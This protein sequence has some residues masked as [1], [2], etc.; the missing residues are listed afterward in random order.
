MTTLVV[1]LKLFRLKAE[2]IK[3]TRLP[4]RKYLPAIASSGEAG[5]SNY[6]TKHGFKMLFFLTV[7]SLYT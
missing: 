3:R 5:G 4:Y 7:F 2:G 1:R 6:C